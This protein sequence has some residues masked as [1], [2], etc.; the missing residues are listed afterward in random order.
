[1]TPDPGPRPGVTIG[2]FV[3]VVL[4]LFSVVILGASLNDIE[5]I[6]ILAVVFVLLALALVRILFRKRE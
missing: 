1:M 2:C 5:L 3:L 6:V 4:V